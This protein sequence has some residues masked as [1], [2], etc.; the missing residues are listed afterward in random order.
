MM[1]ADMGADV[2]KID[3]P[4]RRAGL[5]ESRAQA[6]SHT[7]RNK[8]SIAIDLK[9][10]AGVDV[11]MRL[12]HEADV[13]IE[14]F[15]PGVMNRLGAGYET[16]HALNPKLV[17]CSL[18]GFGSTGP[19]SA[20]PAHD[21]NFLALSGAL[22]LW[23]AGERPDLPLNLVA[24]YGGASMHGA[25]AIMM[26]LFARE[27]GGPGQHIDISYLETTVALLAATPNMRQV[28]SAGKVATAGQGIFCGS[29]PYYTLYRTAD[30]RLLSVACSEPH[31]WNNF[32]QAIGRSDLEMYCRDADHYLRGPNAA[33]LAARLD[34]EGVI[35][36]RN[37][38]HW[39]EFFAA[40]DVCVAPVREVGEML[41][42]SHLLSRGVV[43]NAVHP[44]Y[45]DIP[46]FRS[47]LRLST[48]PAK[49][50][51]PAPQVGEHTTEVLRSLGMEEAAID[52]LRQQGV[53]A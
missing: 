50:G 14:G 17:Y 5:D 3:T 37:L 29:Y 53:V 12:A 9:T 32:C 24:D 26:A 23:G 30:G 11:F 28:F 34:V 4:G 27:R 44:A 38:A 49:V 18:S 43:A 46:Q 20:R 7:N 13:L 52:I 10:Q 48:T 36:A 16:L 41:A 40:F 51:C 22:S 21:L 19:Y 33:E 35:R 15:R 25:L 31:L 42:D 2:L 47:A 39:E 6:F 45:G 1:L 8:R